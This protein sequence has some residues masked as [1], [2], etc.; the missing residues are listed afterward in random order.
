[1]F[2]KPAIPGQDYLK[3]KNLPDSS[4]GFRKDCLLR[5]IDLIA[6]AQFK[7]CTWNK[8]LTTIFRFTVGMKLGLWLPLQRWEICG[9]CRH[10]HRRLWRKIKTAT[11]N[12]RS[13]VMPLPLNNERHPKLKVKHWAHLNWV[14]KTFFFCGSSS[15]LY[16]P[17]VAMFTGKNTSLW[18]RKDEAVCYP[19]TRREN[20]I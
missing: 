11:S 3:H 12:G 5:T 8:M 10:L 4:G 9:R 20:F 14:T 1:M 6:S 16:A 15:S 2:F 18:C 19:T 7:H 17:F 13:G